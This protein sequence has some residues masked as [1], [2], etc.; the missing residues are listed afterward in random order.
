MLSRLPT[1]KSEINGNLARGLLKIAQGEAQVRSSH[2]GGKN[3]PGA[4]TKKKAPAASSGQSG[5]GVAGAKTRSTNQAAASSTG[6]TG[7]QTS[8][9]ADRWEILVRRLDRFHTKVG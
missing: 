7:F 5:Q 6:S 9:A 4:T 3:C 2:T 1:N 8:A